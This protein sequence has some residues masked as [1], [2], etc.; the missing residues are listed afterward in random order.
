MPPTANNARDRTVLVV[1]DE[2]LV[3][4]AV[5]AMLA[6]TGFL[7]LRAGSPHDALRI[8]AYRQEPIH[9]M[10]ADVLMPGL[11][12]PGL[13][14][15]FS[16][17]HP[18]TRYLFMAG[19]AQHPEVVERILRRGLDFIPKPFLPNELARRVSEVLAVR[20]RAAEARA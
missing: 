1:D 8:G 5:S 19:F 15:Q 2:P 9:L 14:D 4:N 11:N 3:L 7:V 17:L 10:L 12:G 13:A 16:R 20:E 6:Y 18:E